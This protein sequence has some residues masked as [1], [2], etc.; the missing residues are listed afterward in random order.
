[1]EEK[2]QT[3][4]AEI[5][6]LTLQG[7]DFIIEQAPDVIT[8]L[9][10]WKFTVSLAGFIIGWVLLLLVGLSIKPL[11]KSCRSGGFLYKADCEPAVCF[12]IAPIIL[13]GILIFDIIWL[14][15][16]IAPKI[17]LLEYAARLVT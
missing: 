3:A 14:Q 9:L 10:A 15:I 13:G 5:I 8:Q 12:L 4:L 17:Y 1:M 2:L 16:L 6:N 11:I 7:K